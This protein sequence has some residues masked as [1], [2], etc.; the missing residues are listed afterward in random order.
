MAVAFYG[1]LFLLAATLLSCRTCYTPANNSIK[2]LVSCRQPVGLIEL[3]AVVEHVLQGKRVAASKKRQPCKAADCEAAA[4]KPSGNAGI[5]YI[6]CIQQHCKP[7]SLQQFADLFM[8]INTAVTYTAS[9][10]SIVLLGATLLPCQ[11]CSTSAD[12]LI[13]PMSHVG[14]L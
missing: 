9:S 12:V 4:S 5:W 2:P 13:K 11:S 6:S 10:L 8:S 14:S 7:A 3:F 1:C